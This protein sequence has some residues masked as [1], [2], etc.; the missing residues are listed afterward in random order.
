MT[1]NF[2]ANTLGTSS[3]SNTQNSAHTILKVSFF[4]LGAMLV[5]FFSASMVSGFKE[6]WTSLKEKSIAIVTKT[7]GTEMKKDE[8]G[9][10]NVLLL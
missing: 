8:N 9:N 1:T 3:E 10:V 4:I 2:S 6:I 7:V 5:L